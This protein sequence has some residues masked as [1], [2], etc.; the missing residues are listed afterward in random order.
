MLIFDRTDNV[1]PLPRVPGQAHKGQRAV[2]SLQQLH[3]KDADL[4]DPA[5]IARSSLF[6]KCIV[7]TRS[8]CG[9]LYGFQRANRALEEIFSRIGRQPSMQY[10]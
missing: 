8:V 2:K 1:S 9:G 10:F 4:K 7:K 5:I 3:L 6:G